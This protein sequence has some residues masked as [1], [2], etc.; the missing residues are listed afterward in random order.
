MMMKR[1]LFILLLLCSCLL[2]ATRAAAQR[3]LPGQVDIQVGAPRL[4]L[5]AAARAAGT[6]YGAGR[7]F[8]AAAA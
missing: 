7:L 3:G 4:P 6:I 1:S 2:P 5:S 8:P